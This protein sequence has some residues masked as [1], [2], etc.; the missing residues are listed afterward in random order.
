MTDVCR[1]FEEVFRTRDCRSKQGKGDRHAFRQQYV[2]LAKTFPQQ[3]AHLLQLVPE[4]GY[5]KDLLMLFQ[6]LYVE[7]AQAVATNVATRRSYDLLKAA[8]VDVLCQYLDRDRQLL[9]KSQAQAQ[10]PADKVH[11]RL[12]ISLAAKYAPKNHMKPAQKAFVLLKQARRRSKQSKASEDK[13]EVTSEVIP[14]AVPEPG[15]DRVKVRSR[16]LK[17]RSQKKTRSTGNS[18]YPTNTPCQQQTKQISLLRTEAKYAYYKLVRDK[19]F[20]DDPAASAKYRKLLSTLNKHLNTTE[21]LM[22]AKRWEDID[23]AKVPSK[24][25]KVHRMALLNE[26]SAA[27]AKPDET[28]KEKEKVRVDLRQNLLHFESQKA[29]QALKDMNNLTPVQVVAACRRRQDVSTEEAQ[30]LER[31]WQQAVA[32]IAGLGKLQVDVAQVDT[33]QSMQT[34]K[35][36]N[37]AMAT[38]LLVSQLTTNDSMRGWIL[39]HHRMPQWHRDDLAKDIV[40]R[41]KS[42]LEAPWEGSTSI[43]N[44]VQVAY[45][46]YKL[47]MCNSSD[48]FDSFDSPDSPDSLDSLD[49]AKLNILMLTDRIYEP[50]WRCFGHAITVWNLANTGATPHCE[51][52][53]TSR[54]H[55]KLLCVNGFSNVALQQILTGIAGNRKSCVLRSNSHASQTHKKPCSAGSAG[56]AGSAGSAGSAESAESAGSAGS[57]EPQGR[58]ERVKKLLSELSKS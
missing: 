18:V 9:T 56:N 3:A 13:P 29:L 14:G 26:S 42:L 2:Q 6:D 53:G 31:L 20:P 30:E 43:Q 10:A 27:E 21:A 4:Y 48:R 22:S 8:T 44:L 32:S 1:Q 25:L 54:N 15:Q 16:K 41:V 19:L 33:S 12:D 47:S 5:F 35:V 58:Y 34:S 7:E 51:V 52:K 50:S 36:L 45:Q 49:S 17:A 38:G 40:W 23:V 28:E 46:K 37:A 39:T 55:C 24:C 11:M 57:A